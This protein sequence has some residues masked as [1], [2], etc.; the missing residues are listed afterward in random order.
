[1]IIWQADFYK[2]SLKNEQG[3]ILW[4]LL[5]CHP[6]NGVIYEAICPQSQANSDWL[7]YQLQQATK[8]NF[9]DVIQVFRPQCVNL[10]TIVGEKLGVKIQA[11]RHTK[12]LK[13]VLQKRTMGATEDPVKLEKPPPQALPENLW[14]DQW[15]LGTI[16]AG[17]I[18]EIWR[19][20]PIPILEMPDSLL[21]INLGVASTISIPGLV[22]YG[23]RKSMQLAFWLQETKP[24]CLNYIPTEVDQSG[25]LLLESGLVDRW[26][27]ATFEDPEIA[28]SAQIYEQQKIASQGLH[29]LLVQP[30]DSGM[31]YTGFWLLLEESEIGNEQ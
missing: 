11:T 3:Q 17:D 1:M 13:E 19:D 21:P 16:A 24:V 28:K 18:V 22:I 15:R 30:D 2:H 4:E 25:G 10:F 12:V 6:Q 27:M 8:D 5:I 7:I 14:G 23:G 20:R 29:F 31:T 26:I 9:P